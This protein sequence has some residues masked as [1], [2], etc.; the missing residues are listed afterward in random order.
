MAEHGTAHSGLSHFSHDP[1]EPQ[2]LSCCSA[3][4]RHRYLTLV[5]QPS[6][7]FT[8]TPLCIV[9][10]ATLRELWGI[11]SGPSTPHGT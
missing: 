9:P 8:G 3:S 1:T 7:G 4:P 2:P 5:E 10:P 11:R 6:G